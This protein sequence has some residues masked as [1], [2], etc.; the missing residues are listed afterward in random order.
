MKIHLKNT[1]WVDGNLISAEFNY[2]V[3]NLILPFL[4]ARKSIPFLNTGSG[5]HCYPKMNKY[6][7]PLVRKLEFH[8]I[9]AIFTLNRLKKQFIKVKN[10]KS[11][12]SR[13]NKI[14]FLALVFRQNEQ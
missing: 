2:E 5:Y 3:Q 4:L 1:I 6:Y 10:V 8:F 14:A 7:E 12:F 9:I 11:S 13:H